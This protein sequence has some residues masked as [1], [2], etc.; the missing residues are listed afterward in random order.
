M[1]QFE[2]LATAINS[3]DCAFH[4]VC[5]DTNCFTYYED[6]TVYP[7][8]DFCETAELKIVN[9]GWSKTVTDSDTAGNNNNSSID[10]I[11]VSKNIN[12]LDYNII[13]GNDYQWYKSNGTGSFPFSDHDLLYADLQ[14]VY[15]DL[16]TKE[17]HSDWMDEHSQ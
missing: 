4:V 17:S 3:D 6:G 9:P 13:N 16:I 1:E 2:Q 7:W 10:Q 11:F 8:K 15:D 12:I 5:A 14:F